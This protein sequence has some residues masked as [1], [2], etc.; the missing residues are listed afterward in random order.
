MTQNQQA[1]EKPAG[2]TLF[3][4]EEYLVFTDTRPDDEHWELIEGRPVLNATP[5][6]YHQLAAG[7]ILS[8]L[9]QFKSAHRANWFPLMGV[10][11]R[12]PASRNSLPQPDVMVKELPPTGSSVSDDALVVF[13]VWSR[14]N[15]K[16]DQ[17]WRRKV[18]PSVPNCR[19][20]VSVSL[21][22]VNVV[23]HDQADGWVPRTLVSLDDCL[24]LPALDAGASSVSLSLEEIYRYTPLGRDHH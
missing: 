2:E 12:V 10:G 18:Y 11:T 19:H 17:A 1:M 8:H 4:I 6:D 23:V 7:N 24:L 15:N 21:K 9:L 22:S 16:A 13:E 14:S 3:T 5:V 20:Y